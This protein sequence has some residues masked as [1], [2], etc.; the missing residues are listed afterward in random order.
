M[1]RKKWC[2]WL[3]CSGVFVVVAACELVTASDDGVRTLEVLA[4]SPLTG[5]IVRST[6]GELSY[7]VTSET[8]LARGGAPLSS[9]TWSV[10]NLS[11]L[12]VGTS[13]NALTGVF[14]SSGGAVLAGTHTFRMTVSDGSRTAT[15]DFSFVVNE[16]QGF[17]P[18]TSFQ[19]PMGIFDLDLP[20][21]N[22]G[23]GYG[24][25]LWALG[26]GELPWSWYLETGSL[27]QGLT[28]DR[29]SGVVRGTPHSSAAGNE[30]TF[31]VLVKDHTGKEAMSDPL[32][33]HIRVRD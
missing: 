30:Y 28:I 22:A 1:R 25:S 17:G 23:H 5:M 15:G 20:D 6:S 14:H 33:Y 26:N 4:H 21:A 8:L 11:A 31:T 9:Y 2:R 10:A 24:A 3:S 29:T 12:P 13:V 27:P 16:Y 18:I 19:Q 7:Y 32:R